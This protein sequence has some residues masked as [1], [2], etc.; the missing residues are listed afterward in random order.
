MI[1]FF[2]RKNELSLLRETEELSHSVAHSQSCQE[3]GA[4]VNICKILLHF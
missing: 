1:K 2:G 4:L 3:T